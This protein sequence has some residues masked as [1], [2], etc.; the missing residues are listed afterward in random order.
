MSKRLVMLETLN[1]FQITNNIGNSAYE[2]YNLI[3]KAK[4][5]HNLG[6]SD[7]VKQI[8]S[9]I[10]AK[11]PNKLIVFS[12]LVE[13]N[14][15]WRID[16]YIYNSGNYGSAKTYGFTNIHNYYCSLYNN[17]WTFENTV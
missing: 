12:G 7:T 15:I 8:F 13:M 3:F 17:K 14:G 2:S 1:F 5:D 11:Y 16:G 6:M 4:Y 9:D 10:K